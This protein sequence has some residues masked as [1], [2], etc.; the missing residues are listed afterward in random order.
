M[1]VARLWDLGSVGSSV[2]AAVHATAPR[3]PFERLL[4]EQPRR[5]SGLT[6]EK[7]QEILDTPKG[8]R[9]GPSTYMTKAEIDEH[10]T[11]FDDLSLIHISEPTRPY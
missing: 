6:D 7:I 5:I 1:S 11:R 9:P 3:A 4:A 10:L 8:Q 2:G